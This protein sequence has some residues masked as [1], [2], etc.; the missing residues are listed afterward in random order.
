MSFWNRSFGLRLTKRFL[1]ILFFLLVAAIIWYLGPT[2]G[3]GEIRP[4][5]SEDAR[6]IAIVLVLCLFIGFWMHLP[7]FILGSLTLCV[8]VWIFSPYILLGDAY[9]FEKTSSRLAAIGGI[10]LITLLYGLWKLLLLL[11]YHPDKFEKF[12]KGNREQVKEDDFR[13]VVA[14]IDN[15]AK[16]V[17]KS[18]RKISKWSHFWFPKKAVYELPWYMVIGTENAGKTATVLSSGQELPLPEQLMRI[19]RESISTKNC[20]CWFSN[21]AIFV[22]TSGKYINNLEENKPEWNSLVKAI[23][24][25]RP[26]KSINGVIISISVNDLMNKSKKEIYELSSKFRE[27]LDQLRNEL[28]IRFPVYV[29]VTKMDL[30]AGFDEYFRSLTAEEREQIWGFS[31]PFGD[32][33]KRDLPF[34]EIRDSIRSELFALES[35]IDKDMNARQLDEYD[36]NDRKKMYLLPQDFRL[37]AEAI[38][39]FGQN[40]FSPSRYDETQKYTSLRGIY[41]VSNKQLGQHSLQ[42]PR[43]IIQKWRDYTRGNSK[44]DTEAIGYR[45]DLDNLVSNETVTGKHF[46]LKQLFENIIKDKNLVRYN[47]ALSTKYRFQT[48]AGHT[49]C[50]ILTVWLTY[51]LITSYNNNSEYLESANTKVDELAVIVDEHVKGDDDR[52]LPS[53]LELSKDIPVLGI[54]DFK[55]PRLSYR[56]GLYVGFDIKEEATGLYNYFLQRWLLRSLERMTL[57]SLSDATYARDDYAIYDKLKTYLMIHNQGKFDKDYL[58]G[59]LAEE[60]QLSG[61]IDSYGQ[62]IVFVSH[63]EELFS[64]PEWY[65]SSVEIDETLVEHARSILRKKSQAAR[66]YDQVKNQAM[67]ESP[68][69]LTLYKL[70]GEQLNNI[71]E[72]TDESLAASG[73]S[74]IFTYDGYHQVFKKK[75]TEYVSGIQEESGWIMG[76]NKKESQLP[77]VKANIKSVDSLYLT[78]AEQ[79]V[80]KLYL[81]DYTK[82]WKTF[83]GSIRLKKLE[84]NSMLTSNTSFDM[85]ILQILSATDS[86]LIDLMGKA[87]KETALTM[88]DTEYEIPE[89]RGF[90]ATNRLSY[91]AARL[92]EVK[93]ALSQREK[94]VLLENVDR[95]FSSLHKLVN[96]DPTAKNSKT[97]L[98]NQGDS[99]LNRIISMLNDQYNYLVIA[100]SSLT[101]GSGLPPSSEAAQR[102]KADARM[103][104]APL[105]EIIVPL[106][107]GVANKVNKQFIASNSE[108]VKMELGSSCRASFQG[109]YPFTNSRQEASL[110]EFA[111]FFGPN[112]VVDN[113]FQVNLAELVDTSAR[114]WRYKNPELR[115]YESR[116]VLKFFEQAQDIKRA[117]F[118]NGLSE[119]VSFKFSISIPYVSPEILQ[120]SI[121]IDGISMYY[122]HGPIWS[123]TFEWPQLASESMI[124]MSSVAV[125]DQGRNTD[126]VIA[127]QWSLLRWMDRANGYQKIS[128]NKQVLIYN[129]NKQKVNLSITGL[130]YKGVPINRLLKDFKCPNI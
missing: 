94:R 112:G 25:N 117:F 33:K 46:F 23:K 98:L 84:A 95:H 96:L 6:I 26:L 34:V 106:L 85:Y 24:K 127:G 43:S 77:N 15:A 42:N 16:Y 74:G 79:E 14:V 31:L 64:D 56:Y 67:K 126:E 7:G 55:T 52:L 41:F 5:E 88:N 12:F 53:I 27:Q 35:R 65:S 22:D 120:Y 101:Q 68:E 13:E 107:G 18:N 92:K 59:A 51:G 108:S 44:L 97:A 100:E 83:L 122:K 76:E 20:E 19:S 66:I 70:G 75:L 2:F 21:E 1:I 49:L 125:N 119:N 48:I 110:E 38:T 36:I 124:N 103:W 118:Q 47:L 114:P 102:L 121:N 8:C 81:Q 40:V 109:V 63:L 58:V 9:P 50:L 115:G 99:N 104:P 91:N 60:A 73:I 57:K 82:T 111:S 113:Y 130:N 28:G 86:P 3:Y 123:T 39:E 105:K 61:M 45:A 17:T 129:I 90:N 37:L 54:F 30:V 32:K 62:T 72:V 69:N 11:R 93:S 29:V 10:L 116:K 80:L 71:L 78:S 4:L 89:I 128:A 87:A